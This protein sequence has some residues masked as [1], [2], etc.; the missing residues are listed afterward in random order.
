MSDTKFDKFYYNGSTV[1]L[2]NVLTRNGT[3]DE[4]YDRFS[5]YC[6]YCKEA[7]LKFVSA[8]SRKSA[9]LATW[10]GEEH[11]AN[12]LAGYTPAYKKELIDYYKSLSEEQISD[13]L[14]VYLRILTNRD[15]GNVSSKQST[16]AEGKSSN[17]FNS[18]SSTGK[19]LPHRT[20]KTIPHIEDELRNLPILFYGRAYVGFEKRNFSDGPRIRMF[21]RREDTGKPFLYMNNGEPYKYVPKNFD[22]T[23]LY[24][25]VFIGVY[26]SKRTFPDLIEAGAFKLS[27]AN[28]K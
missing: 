19:R 20:L 16:Q 23:I 9:Y 12:C 10:V 13:K 8:T 5:L 2:Y 27:P 21:L 3:L 22:D 14:D 17:S 25:V 4:Q 24:N 1:Y 15:N 26:K 11:S 18:S 7:R 28:L 6:P